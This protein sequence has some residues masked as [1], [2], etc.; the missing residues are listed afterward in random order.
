MTV[1][2]DS[3]N[4]K[5]PEIYQIEVTNACNFNCEFCLR[6]FKPRLSHYLDTGLARVISERDLGGS[7]FV[8][9][10][11]AGEPLLHP[12]LKDIVGF[13]KG[14]VLI[15]LSTNGYLINTQIEAL[16]LLDYVT[17]SIDSVTCYKDT[18]IGGDLQILLNN[19][20]LLLTQRSSNLVIDLQIVEL[21]GWEEEKI[22][23]EELVHKRKWDVNIRTVPDCFLGFVNKNIKVDCKEMCLNPFMSVS[24]QADGDVTSCCFSFGKD[25]VY[26]NLA[27]KSLKEVW[28][29]SV[30]ADNLRNEHKT[31]CFREI[32]SQCYM[33]SPVLLHWQIFQNSIFKR[34]QCLK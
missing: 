23:L 19:I 20:E 26:G 9:F 24:I 34:L 17:I 18:R 7:Y 31:G 8:E 29:Q 27:K 22:K 32:C 4:P 21:I 30:V 25:I 5:I 12:N 15:G 11:M 28:Q 13:Y 6:R 16:K 10:Q 2:P 14:K 3:F 33:R 1:F